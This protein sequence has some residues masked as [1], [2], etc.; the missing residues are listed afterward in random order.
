MIPLSF[1]QRRL[2]FIT[3]LEGPSP[4]Y[5]VPA[6]LRLTG[7][8]DA[9]ALGAALRDVIVRHEVL[10]TVFPA[11]EGEPYQR[12]LSARELDWELE[13]APV[14]PAELDAAVAA[15]TAYPFDLSA[16]VPVRAWLFETGPEEHV[17]VLVTHHIASDGWSA[18][19]L[20]RD[21]GV[22]YAARRAGRVPGWAA[23]PVQYADYALWQRE[24][25][26]TE[27]DPDS[28]LSQQVAY[29]RDALDGV[30]QE[31]VLPADRPRPLEPSHRAVTGQLEVPAEL[32]RAL[33]A[34]AQGQGA[35]LYMVL[36]AALVV[37]LSRLG[38]GTDIPVGAPVAGRTDEALDDLVGFFVNTLVLRTDL[39]GDP[40]LHE[41]LTQVRTSTLAGL[42][43]QDVPFE[44]LVEELAP[45]RSLARHPL[46]QVMLVLQN[47]ERAVADL[48]GLRAE[49]LPVSIRDARFDLEVSIAETSGPGG[50]PAGLRGVVVATA[51]L[52][53]EPTAAAI[54]ER[55]VRVLEV[56][57]GVPAT[58]LSDVD[59]LSVAE[60]RQVVQEWND[61]TAPVP[62]VTVAGLFAEQV[63]RVPDAV[64]VVSGDAWLSYRELDVRAGRLAGWL[65]AAGVGRESVVGLCLPR[66]AEWVRA[67]LGV[68]KAGAA[69]LPL[70]PG[71]PAERAGFMLADSG[72]VL[73]LAAGESA[74]ALAG[75]GVPVVDLDDP[76]TAAAVAGSPAIDA[77]AGLGDLAYVI[78]T[79]GSTGVPKGV[80][81]SQGALANY[82]VSVPGRVGFAGEGLRFALLQG[83]GADLG[84]T[85]V[86]GALASGGVLHV[87]DADEVVDPAAVAGYVAGRA[88]DCVKVV[89]SHLAALAAGGWDGLVPARSLVLGGEG[90][91]AGWVRELAAAAGP[92]AV[93]NH[94]G[95]T[96]ATI[97]VV[98]G[99]LTPEV[100]ASG[101]VPIGTP[102]ANTRCFV[103]DEWLSPVPPGVAGEL[104]VAGA[105][106]ARGYAG[107]AGLTAERFVACPFGAG[108]ER[109]YR[110][111]DRARWSRSGL[112]EFAGRSDEQ[113]KIRGF[114]V[115]PGEVQAVLAAYPG[116]AQAAVIARDDTE[117]EVRLVGYVAPQSGADLS[118]P[119][120]REHAARRLPDY[121]VPAA[122]ITLDTL[123]V[124]ANG[125][126]DRRA[127]PA[128]DWAAAGRGGRGPSGPR[129]EILGQAFADV[130]G[131]PAVGVYDDFFALGGHSLLAVRLISRVRAVLGVEVALRVLFE[132]PTVAGLA[133]RLDEAG[134]ARLALAAWERPERVPL[135]FAQQRLWF[136]G[137]LEGPSSTYNVPVAVRLSGELDA[138]ALNAALRDVIERHEVLRTIFPA[139]DGEPYQKILSPAELDWELEVVPVAAADLDAAVAAAAGHA[140]DLSAEVPVRA[141]LFDAG[142]GEHVLVLVMHHIASDGWSAAPLGRDLGVAYAARCAGRAPQWAPL[143]VQYA[144]YALWQRELLGGEDDSDSLLSRQVGYWREVLDGAP[145]ELA[146]PAD[147]PRPAVSSVRGHS[148]PLTVPPE[149]HRALA[150][151]ARAEGVT[152][153][154]VLQAALVVLLSRLGAGTDIPVG[155]P[156]AGRT[157]E[158]LDDLVGF[159]VNTLV[160][161]TDL[162]GDPDFSTLLGR[163]RRA[164]LAG[165][166]HQ[167][168][169]F[170]RLVGE[171]APVRSLARHPLFQVMLVLQNAERA[172]ADLAGLQAQGMP[173]DIR[174]AKLDL[175]VNVAETFGAGGEPAGLRG[176]VVASADLFDEATAVA[177]AEQF[178]R[179]LWSVAADPDT[180]V[181]GVDVLGV[182]ERRRVVG[183]WNDTAAAMP[184]VSGPE[185]FAERA[186][187]VPD[188]VAVV[189]GDECVSY[190]ELDARAGRLAGFLTGLGVGRESVVA[191]M[192][193]RGAG[194]VTALL[195]VWQAGAGY[196]PVD[197]GLP[198]ERV[199]FMLADS[200]AVVVLAEGES[201]E[202]VA[203]GPVPVVD[204]DD[205]GTAAVVAGS[206]VAD[207]PGPGDAGL[208]DLAYVIYTS[209]S[210]GRPKGVAISH[211]GIANRLAWMQ[212]EYQLKPGDRVLQKTPCGFDVSVWE[213]FWPL[214]EGAGLVMARPDGHRDPA[215]LTAVIGE[216]QVTMVHFVPSMLEVFLQEPGAAGC[217][218]LRKVFCSGE[219]LSPEAVARFFQ[220]LPGAELHNL[221]GPTEASVDVT[222]WPCLRSTGRGAGA[223]RDTGRQHPGVHPR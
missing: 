5:N 111:G 220:V 163:V 178:L 156:V 124:T 96:E 118:G 202:V 98:T 198:A 29:W 157:D 48:A 63:E 43:H 187:R 71:L 87:L 89:P 183:E 90:A 97:G 120:I 54:A 2:W 67:V 92:A 49:G 218:G 123:P 114:R 182:E 59:V 17:L 171:L 138:G 172:V 188:A 207:Q 125:K 113:V 3:Q 190:G 53:D 184:A 185:L 73:V 121:M 175:E 205:A 108:A 177:I 169:P 79:S 134:G 151:L 68:W 93:F 6:V 189:S 154:M 51:D 153:Y 137:Q 221:Y 65:R 135:S 155:A 104:Y 101:T 212:A 192:M 86:F 62:P 23:L 144:D 13:V 216:Q 20:V 168:V 149:L 95:P 14:A 1:A 193:P 145:Q 173:V 152:V 26:G 16:E 196:L 130:L 37:L 24:L 159:F 128:P 4:I 22:A 60:R 76:A 131:L 40:T 200:G 126:L 88:V 143:P 38:A 70:D 91:P 217:S 85:V 7:E 78:Y 74:A 136:I 180:R 55:F 208:D 81:V 167:D 150:A 25:L 72:A 57:A 164:V 107:R 32:H 176:A 129:E 179:V 100:L 166:D 206:P 21:L 83:Q 41:V 33:A 199:G 141:W 222:A 82:V 28:V 102:V 110:T 139:A 50:E 112:L 162:S 219:A 160:L 44:K 204:L 132:A 69:Y 122:V 64:A 66:G 201:A 19:P 170:E 103:L 146:L 27:D 8:L 165:L 191:V 161:R 147:R 12:I 18:A 56:L 35:T 117:G 215:Y 77:G 115:E 45:V 10:R 80:A 142:L 133:A 30:P 106:L 36:Q 211:R 174:D 15:A 213:F 75:S 11:L 197:P 105:Q 194:L 195:G 223:D 34:L 214:L 186:A 99:P 158:A 52:F 84:N 94:Y 61:T 109:M 31:L 9:G 209:G 42:D 46:F 119:A 116:V 181:S 203:G 127:L 140:F 39:S 210:T 58:R 148:A 47:A